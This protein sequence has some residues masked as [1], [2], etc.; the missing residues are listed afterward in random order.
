MITAYDATIKLN[1]KLIW[2]QIIKKTQIKII[3]S[4]IKYGIS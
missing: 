3:K 4:V 1:K 2:I